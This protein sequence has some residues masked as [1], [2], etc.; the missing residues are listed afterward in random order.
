MKRFNGSNK[1]MDLIKFPI[2]GLDLS[3]FFSSKNEH[4][5]KLYDLF[6]VCNH[7]GDSL[8]RGHYRSYV[9]YNPTEEWYNFDDAKV[10]KI[11]E[12]E[13]ITNDAY[14][15]YTIEKEN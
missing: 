4:N 11:S 12:K 3:K 13:I 10:T 5:R 9:K 8:S 6:A 1:I 7:I 14:I 15:F 2:N